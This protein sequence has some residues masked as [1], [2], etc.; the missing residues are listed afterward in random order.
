MPVNPGIDYQLA[1]EEYKRASGNF[2]KI[3]ALEKMYATCPKHKGS[4]KLLQQIE[5]KIS[6]LRSQV[7]KERQT[8]KGGYSI[9]VKKEG[10]AQI[11]LMGV[12]NTGK[13]TILKELTN[14]KPDIA[15]YEFTTTMP[16]VG[17]LDYYGVKLQIIELPAIFD[18]YADKG[19]G[20]SFMAITRNAQLVV[21]VL[22]GTKPLA[23]QLNLIK[24][25]C[26]NSF[27]SI[28]EEKAGRSK[29]IPAIIT[30]TK[31]CKRPKTDLQIVKPEHLKEA[32][33]K[34]LNLIYAF[35]K[36]PSKERDWPPVA[37]KTGATVKDL[38]RVVH[39]DFVKKF[40]Y[41]R[42]WGKSVKHDGTNAGLD[43]KLKE[44]DIVE[45]HLK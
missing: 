29:P 22:D 19:N 34:N 13:S 14:A 16:E 6:K 7:E 17:T 33:W 25:E 35:T 36:Q 21:I 23:E 8:K 44:G 9:T 2:Q 24:E 10:A 31:Q 4:E 45:L 27:L 28:G 38:A 20:P 5:T 43:H 32:I 39:K 30:V 26:D 12:T 3:K 1:E 41:A 18:G 42:V 15:E 37:L 11:I 40:K